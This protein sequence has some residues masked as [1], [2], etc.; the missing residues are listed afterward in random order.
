[1]D[2]KSRLC[3]IFKY[4]CHLFVSTIPL[5]LSLPPSA[6]LVHLKYTDISQWIA[7]KASVTCIT[8]DTSS[9]AVRSVTDNNLTKVEVCLR[10]FSI[11][12]QL[13]ALMW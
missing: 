4:Q 6:D 2:K 7:A 8:Q 9:V 1:M 5:S 3:F 10:A 13:A 12:I 11:T